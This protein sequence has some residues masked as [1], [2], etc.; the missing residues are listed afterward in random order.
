MGSIINPVCWRIVEY[1]CR[2][3]DAPEREAVLGDLT[4]SGCSAPQ[5]LGNVLGLMIRRQ[6]ELWQNW[7]PWI[8][9]L[10]VAVVVAVPLSRM[11][12]NFG[13]AVGL[14]IRTYRHYGVRYETGLSFGQDLAYLTCLLSACFLWS[15]VSG[16]VLGSL[17]GRTIWL[18]GAAFYLVALNAF[19][20]ILL[21]SGNV[22]FFPWWPLSWIVLSLLLPLNIPAILFSIAAIWGMRQGFM[23]RTVDLRR[24]LALATVTAA[25]TAL[26][27]WMSG[28]YQAVGQIY[29]A[30]G[31]HG[32]SWF[33][34][35]L[36]FLLLA[37][38]VCYLLA[39]ATRHTRT[40]AVTNCEEPK[41]EAL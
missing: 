2:S 22:R 41:H 3:L 28:W 19:R 29:S 24:A 33:A 32:P 6:C 26:L 20:G 17:S 12:S 13:G 21:L 36:P 25:L 16:F 40:D 31:W 4:E 7:Q 39:T 11:T 34:R 9:L 27:I 18:T 15:W 38:P 37:W 5:A 14:Q 8:A 30:G 10:A 1:V 35:S 23:Q